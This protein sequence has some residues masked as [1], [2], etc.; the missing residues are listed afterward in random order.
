MYT[1]L[2]PRKADRL[3]AALAGALAVVGSSFCFA[4][5]NYFVIP[6]TELRLLPPFCRTG[7]DGYGL[8]QADAAYMNHLCPGLYAL[9]DGQR[10]LGNDAQRKY[11]LQ[12]AVDHLNYTLNHTSPA[13]A[14]RSMVLIKRGNAFELQGNRAKAIADYN[15]AVASQPKNLLG[16]LSLCNAY[17]KIG[18]KKS[19]RDAADT[20]LKIKPDAKPLM[21]CKQKA[22]GS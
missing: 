20:G 13:F 7:V 14:L 19:A 15:A 4:Q 5:K 10:S 18:D 22:E 1:Y 17:L 9:N 8:N 11:A 16:Y 12:E 6:E 2:R 21:A 3:V